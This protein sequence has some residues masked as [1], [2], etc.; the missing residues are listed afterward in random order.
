MKKENKL[1]FYLS[2]LTWGLPYTI[3]SF[4]VFLFIIIFLR[5]KVES[6]KVVHGRLQVA[7]ISENLGGAS[8][9]FFYLIGADIKNSAHVNQHELGHTI[10]LKWYGPFFI[11]IALHS[12]IRAGLWDRLY[13][14][15]YKKYGKYLDYDGIWFE[16]QAT[17]LGE[18][19]F[20]D[21]KQ[22]T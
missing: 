4:L 21:I 5:K 22:Y 9:G 19:Y 10:Q 1:L 8:F 3:I 7:Y 18:Q 13:D 16:G 17:K 15:H 14:R 12:V 11:Y 6:I 2:I 20:P